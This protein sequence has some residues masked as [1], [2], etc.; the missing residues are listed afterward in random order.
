MLDSVQLSPHAREF[1]ANF[2]SAALDGQQDVMALDHQVADLD[3]FSSEE[4]LAHRRDLSFQLFGHRCAIGVE[5]R[6]TAM[7]SG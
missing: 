5:P 3:Q 4:G 2:R 6:D 1:D 7:R